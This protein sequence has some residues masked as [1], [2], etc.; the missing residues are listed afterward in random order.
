MA[1]ARRQPAASLIALL[2]HD[3]A[4]FEADQV[5]RILTARQA[6]IGGAPVRYR[7]TLSLAFAPSDV[8]AVEVPRT[9]APPT[10]APIVTVAF[11]GLGG[12]TGPLP[13]P[14]IEHLA[15][16][17]RRGDSAGQDFLDLFN[18]RLIAAA[19]DGA[20]LFRPV[21]QPG[22]PEESTLARQ[23]RALLGLGTPGLVDALA[24]LGPELEPALLPLAG[25]LNQRP[26]SAHAIER[27]LA[28]LI[29]TAVA[30]AVRVRPFRGGWLP[31]P[32]GQRTAIGRPGRNRVLGV[33]AVLGA[34][35]WQQDAGIT[36]EIGPV[37]LAQ[38]RRLLPTGALFATLAG[39]LDFVTDDGQ[40]AAL[41]LIVRA[42]TLPRARLGR[43]GAMRLGWTAWLRTSVREGPRGRL[44]A[45]RLGRT[46]RLGSGRLA[47]S[48]G[49]ASVAVV[50]APR[51]LQGA[52]R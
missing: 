17:A 33:D 22:T 12:A 16:A 3:V 34:R 7:G 39:V 31:L 44:D 41:R 4:R 13:T 9:D 47:G 5:A 27:A 1:R 42:D 15:A 48:P 37:T 8:I 25:L 6:R 52:I 35:A 19:F 2:R 26:V 28:V 29:G 11:L 50:I 18:H 40:A 36:V 14:Y 10:D 43:A 30:G 21:L 51:H 49:P 23:C 46:A 32:D 45:A 24:H 20:R 38:A